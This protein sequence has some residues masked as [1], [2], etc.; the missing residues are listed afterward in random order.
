MLPIV[1]RKYFKEISVNNSCIEPLGRLNGL[2]KHFIIR[3]ES[4]FSVVIYDS[5]KEFIIFSRDNVDSELDELLDIP[6]EGTYVLQI[7]S[8]KGN[9]EVYLMVQE[10]F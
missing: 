5:E 9:F 10:L 8:E 3:S 7:D 6:V 1:F 4:F 2:I